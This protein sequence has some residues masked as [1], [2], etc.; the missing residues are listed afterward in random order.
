MI[1]KNLNIKGESLVCVFVN[2]GTPDE[3]EKFHKALCSK[4]MDE[5][6]PIL[7]GY[8][9]LQEIDKKAHACDTIAGLEALQIEQ[10]PE[11]MFEELIRMLNAEKELTDQERI[12]TLAH[13][14]DR[15]VFAATQYVTNILQ[16]RANAIAMKPKSKIITTV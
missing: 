13:M 16:Q 14:G 11:N 5:Y 2:R 10:V 9:K 1:G 4:L 3:C 6:Y 15:L 12:F 7:T 8:L